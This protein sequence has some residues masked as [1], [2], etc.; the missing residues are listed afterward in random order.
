M[1]GES[2]DPSWEVSWGNICSSTQYLYSGGGGGG[3]GG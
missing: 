2:I 1:L 3:G